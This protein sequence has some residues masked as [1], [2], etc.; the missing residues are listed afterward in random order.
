MR[1]KLGHLFTLFCLVPKGRRTLCRGGPPDLVP[2]PCARAVGVYLVPARRALGPSMLPYPC[3]I[4]VPI[5]VPDGGTEAEGK[6]P[7]S[8]AILVPEGHQNAS[9]ETLCPCPPPLPTVPPM[10][11]HRVRHK[12][13]IRG[14]CHIYIYIERERERVREKRESESG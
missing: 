6:C 10:S 14:H 11:A 3:A 4:L 13:G 9:P 5:L 12:K 8:F 1:P 7:N 2:V